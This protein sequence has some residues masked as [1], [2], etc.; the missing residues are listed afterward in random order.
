MII[1][2]AT[3]KDLVAYLKL[4]QESL[5][6]YSKI[7]GKKIKYNKKGSIQEFKEHLN[8]K[9]GVILFVVDDNELISYLMGNFIENAYQKMSYI[10]D[11]FV[12]KNYRN[13]G[14]A[15][16]LMKEFEKITKLKHYPKIR[17]GVNTK[18]ASAIELYKKLGFKTVHYDMEKMIG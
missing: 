7:A 6:D 8:F 12:L 1:R 9:K 5:K 10:D 17:L 2:K 3:S 11:V 4:K 18:N 14:I 16:L 15:T 13:K